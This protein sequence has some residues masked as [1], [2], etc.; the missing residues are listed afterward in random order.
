VRGDEMAVVRR[1]EGAAEQAQSSQ[2]TEVPPWMSR[3]ISVP[4]KSL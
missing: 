3:L 4:R 1:I 2:L